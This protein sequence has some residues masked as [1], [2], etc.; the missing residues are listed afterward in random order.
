MEQQTKEWHELRK[1][2]IG[3]SD[4]PVIMGVSPWK[5]PAQL[6]QEK[7]GLRK[8]QFQ[9]SAMQRGLALEE[10]ARKEFVRL[11]G[12]DM[13]PAVV[14]SDEYDFMMASLD[15]LSNNKKHAVEIK[16][17]YTSKDH[18]LALSGCVPEKYMPQL[19]H[20]MVVC[21]LEMIFY[22]SYNEES[23]KIIEVKRDDD[24]IN[25]LIKKEVEFWDCWQNL[26][27]PR[28]TE[29]DYKERKDYEW[30][31]HASAWMDTQCQLKS[32]QEKEEMQRKVLISLSGEENSRGAGITLSKHVRR[33]TVD[34][35]AIPELSSVDM[36]MYRKKPVEYWRIGVE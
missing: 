18:D 4:S 20:Q 16:C 9:S 3:A 31:M 24:Y 6:W 26:E 32:L 19:Q 7:L 22:F 30:R 33:G 36:E 17:P 15:G 34:Y 8:S 27:Q 5:T 21:K 1:T 13:C 25:S 28:L 12:I 14:V 29:R 11:T 23:S 35:K 2:K 10:P